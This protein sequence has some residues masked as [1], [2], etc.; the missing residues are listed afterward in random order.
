ML[1][2]LF[3]YPLWKQKLKLKI[4][5]VSFAIEKIICA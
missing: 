3:V 4:F 2:F 5:F 1:C